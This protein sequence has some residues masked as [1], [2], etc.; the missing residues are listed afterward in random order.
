MKFPTANAIWGTI[1]TLMLGAVIYATTQINSVPRLIE[2]L[3]VVERS[4]DKLSDRIRNLEID[5]SER[6]GRDVE[7]SEWE[8][9]QR[10]P[11]KSNYDGKGARFGRD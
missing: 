4:T 10:P 6:R 3:D 7:R 5:A 11:A 1:M 2:R 8:R 9:A